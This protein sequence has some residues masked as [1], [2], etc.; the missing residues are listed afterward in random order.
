MP[1][2]HVSIY[3]LERMRAM[4]MLLPAKVA[5]PCSASEETFY[6]NV[7]DWDKST[8]MPVESPKPAVTIK[9]SIFQK[10]WNCIC[11][12]FYDIKQWIRG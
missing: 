9:P 8:R 3:K 1:T 11:A 4:R 12:L 2:P 5:S 6:G 10:L 7:H